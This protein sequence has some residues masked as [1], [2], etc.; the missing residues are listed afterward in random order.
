MVNL[1]RAKNFL[2]F[3]KSY[4]FTYNSF[5]SIIFEKFTLLKYQNNLEMYDV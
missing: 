4:A 5:T 2:F 1:Y 3:F